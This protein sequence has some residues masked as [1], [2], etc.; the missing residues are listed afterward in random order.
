MQTELVTS[1]KADRRVRHHRR[2]GPDF[3]PL[4]ALNAGSNPTL[5]SITAYTAIGDDATGPLSTLDDAALP[6]GTV[7]SPQIMLGVGP[8]TASGN[9]VAFDQAA[10]LTN[11]TFTAEIPNLTPPN[12]V[13]WARACLGNV[14][15]P[16]FPWPSFVKIQAITKTAVD[17]HP[18]L[19]GETAPNGSVTIK[20]SPD[21]FS[22]FT[23]IGSVTADPN[24]IFD[25]T[26][27]SNSSSPAMR[28][29]YEASV[30]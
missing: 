5:S 27:I 15:G 29:F 13:L 14:C 30:P 26:D 4:G 20:F 24:G 3:A 23:P 28:G 12:S 7:P 10:T 1:L 11:G 2:R 19:T 21:L 22:P 25:F 17:A 8:A 6:D 18:I 16:A 9:S